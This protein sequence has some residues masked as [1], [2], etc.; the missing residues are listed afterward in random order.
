MHHAPKVVYEQLQEGSPSLADRQ[1]GKVFGCPLEVSAAL[2][3]AS[4]FPG[5]SFKG[6]RRASATSQIP[7]YPLKV[8]VSGCIHRILGLSH[9][10]RVVRAERFLNIGRS[11]GWKLTDPGKE[12]ARTLTVVTYSC[13]AN[14]VHM[15]LFVSDKFHVQR[16]CSGQASSVDSEPVQAKQVHDVSHVH[17]PYA[18]VS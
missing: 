12:R 9:G 18:Y 4:N 5:R 10:T 8:T 13:Q 1:V 16:V 2:I 11:N 15:S 6:L 17:V 14:P 7:R 3:M